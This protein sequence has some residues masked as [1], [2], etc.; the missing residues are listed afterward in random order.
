MMRR[1]LI[2]A[3]A[4]LGIAGSLA[5]AG[6]APASA[7]TVT[8]IGSG[9]PTGGGLLTPPPSWPTGTR[10]CTVRADANDPTSAILAVVPSGGQTIVQGVTGDNYVVTCQNG[11]GSIRELMPEAQTATAAS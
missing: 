5:L 6:I 1:T 7:A 2:R 3:V 9:G 11:E 8:G 4:S 10:P